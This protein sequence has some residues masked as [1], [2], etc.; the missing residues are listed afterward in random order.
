MPQTIEI[1]APTAPNFPKDWPAIGLGC[2][3]LG[4]LFVNIPETEAAAL[5]AAAWESGIRYFDTAPWYGHGLSEHRLG[6]QIRQHSRCESIVSSKV[7]RVYLAPDRGV[8]ARIQW[9]GGLNF[10]VHYDYSATGFE[11]SLSQSQMRLGQSAIDALIIHDLDQSYH[12]EN[13]DKHM[14]DLTSTGLPWLHRIKQAGQISAVG[15]GINDLYDFAQVAE[16]IDVD[17]FLVAM[18][19]TLLDQCALTGPMAACEARGI[20]IVIGAPLASGLL[21]DPQ[22]STLLYNYAPAS[23]EIRQKA[24]R[25][26]GICRRYDIPLI[27]AALQF[28]LLHPAV[29]SVVP[30]AISATQVRQNVINGERPIPAE[31]WIE[32]KAQGLIHTDAPID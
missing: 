31:M 2:A 23:D 12:G 10:G 27:A 32:L 6:A 4:E 19:Y 13:F 14:N 11:T 16:W 20:K 5:L 8:D 7:G 22:N 18:P 15:M 17:F 28:P 9:H 24:L 30:G 29:V 21:A 1:T 26:E 3:P 25:I